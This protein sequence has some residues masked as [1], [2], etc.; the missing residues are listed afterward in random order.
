MLIPPF[1]VFKERNFLMVARM[2]EIMKSSP[3]KPLFAVGLAH[4]TTGDYSF[5]RLLESAGYRL[6]RVLAGSLHDEEV[7]DADCEGVL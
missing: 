7:S 6:E 4:W 2:T 5:Q 1:F 3:T